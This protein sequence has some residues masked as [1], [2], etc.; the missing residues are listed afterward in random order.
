[1]LQLKD[2][3]VGQW[4]ELCIGL[5]QENLI[6]FQVQTNLPY[7]PQ[8]VVCVHTTLSYPKVYMFAIRSTCYYHVI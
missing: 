3:C 6:E 1:M 4:G 2:L 8:T 7:I 5:T